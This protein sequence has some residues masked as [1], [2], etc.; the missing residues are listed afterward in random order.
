M[1]FVLN[2]YIHENRLT[3]LVF[4]APLDYFFSILTPFRWFSKLFSQSKSPLR[5]RNLPSQSKSK[6]P[7]VQNLSANQRAHYRTRNLTSQSKS[8]QKHA[9]TQGNLSARDY[10]DYSQTDL[11]FDW[12]FP[13]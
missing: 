4:N 2:P 1:D 8:K 10:F 12:L 7:Q 5:T 13:D 9:T 6:Q 3:Q 11:D